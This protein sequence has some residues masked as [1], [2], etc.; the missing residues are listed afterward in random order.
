MQS[1]ESDTYNYLKYV[2]SQPNNHETLRLLYVAMTR[3]KKEIHLLGTLNKSNKPNANTLLALLASKFQSQFDETS[4]SILETDRTPPEA[5]ALVRYAE[6]ADYQQLDTS[7]HE[8]L[9][10][11]LSIELQF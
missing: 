5:P 1:Q 11:Q 4:S 8:Q 7:A 2:E 10:L 6:L 3:A 9:D